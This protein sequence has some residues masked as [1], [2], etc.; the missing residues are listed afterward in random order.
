V[1]RTDSQKLAVAVQKVLDVMVWNHLEQLQ[2]SNRTLHKLA[3]LS[4]ARYRSLV[5]HVDSVLTMDEVA[6]KYDDIYLVAVVGFEDGEPQMAF[7]KQHS[8]IHRLVMN[9]DGSLVTK[10]NILP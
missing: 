2:M 1:N 10:C 8:N 3:N 6:S 4:N 7:I 5:Q 9:E